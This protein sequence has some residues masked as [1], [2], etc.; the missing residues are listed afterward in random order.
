MALTY[1]P[2]GYEVANGTWTTNIDEDTSVVLTGSRS[3]K[4]LDTATN[5]RLRHKASKQVPVEAGK[6]YKAW[7]AY[8]ATR[9]NSGDN[10][11]LRIEWMGADR[12]TTVDTDIV[13]NDRVDAVDT[14]EYSELVAEAPASSYYARLHF[15]RDIASGTGMACY[16]DEVDMAVAVPLWEVWTDIGTAAQSV[17]TAT[18]TTILFDTTDNT[19]VDY[20]TGT[21]QVTILIPG[22][23]YVSAGITVA[24]LG[25]NKRAFW[26]ARVNGT[27]DHYLDTKT[28]YAGG[29]GGT[30]NMMVRGA[31]MLPLEI[32]DT[33]EMILNHNHGSNRDVVSGRPQTRFSGVR[34][35]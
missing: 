15:G 6:R 13:F 8:R 12:S 32:G 35:L 10:L 18:D 23:Y 11:M 16:F 29:G 7:G 26:I 3:V 27:D 17:A 19:D 34:V 24:S 1:P 9:R 31:A 14:W 4:F 28:N 33:V 21:G 30:S 20:D 5:G 22:R 25:D 2:D